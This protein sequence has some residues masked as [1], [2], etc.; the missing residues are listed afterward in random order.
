MSTV[1]LL[2]HAYCL[3]PQDRQP[4]SKILRQKGPLTLQCNLIFSATIVILDA[5]F[6]HFHPPLKTTANYITIPLSCVMSQRNR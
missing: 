1:H 3:G 5:K 6:K 4:L 2:V